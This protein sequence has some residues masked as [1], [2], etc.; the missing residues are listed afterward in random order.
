MTGA[1][2]S[3]TA[4]PDPLRIVVADD[5][6]SIREGLAIML[7]LLPG[8]DVVATAADGDEALAQVGRH[9]PDVVLMDLHM[10]RMDGVE[11]TRRLARDHPRVAVVVLTT[12]VDDTS[13]LNALR[14]GAR[15]YLT[16]DADRADIAAALYAARSGLAV[17]DPRA[18][19][20]LL[21]GAPAAPATAPATAPPPP[22]DGP[23]PDGL[24]AREA[25]VLALA[26][27][28]LSNQEIGA[29]LFLSNNTVKTH[30]NRIFAKTGCR[31]RVAA[32]NYARRHGLADAPP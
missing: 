25:E 10:P 28:G 21:A 8:I 12:Y 6:A 32:A 5:Q 4:G 19:G 22:R 24:T 13:V 2:A 1:P 11:A 3:G 7:D 15:S 30:I 14:A 18:R 27:R 31:D 26:A 16:K 9:H 17:L 20:A 23:P 29:T